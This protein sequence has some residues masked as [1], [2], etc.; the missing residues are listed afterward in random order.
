MEEISLKLE[1]FVGKINNISQD[2]LRM[3]GRISSNENNT[4]KLLNFLETN[5]RITNQIPDLQE[6]MNSNKKLNLPF[7][8]MA[9]SRYCSEHG[10]NF[11]LEKTKFEDTFGAS[12]FSQGSYT[13]GRSID[14]NPGFNSSI[15]KAT[16]EENYHS[17]QF[18]HNYN[19][20]PNQAVNYHQQN[21]QESV[22][23]S[24]LMKTTVNRNLDYSQSVNPYTNQNTV[25]SNNFDV[26]NPFRNGALMN[27]Q[28]PERNAALVN[29]IEPERNGA[30]LNSMEPE[31]K[32][33][34]SNSK[35]SQENYEIGREYMDDNYDRSLKHIYDTGKK[36][37]E[38]IVIEDEEIL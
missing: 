12:K 8:S 23:Q 9:N 18:E 7:D 38:T 36:V 10:N 22:Y 15:D 21:I 20:Q 24:N 17:P 19:Q 25:N 11:T 32:T 26:S 16:L 6:N 31:K 34:I 29:S 37:E 28:E 1:G 3:E 13:Q 14:R 4:K 30:L 27:S 35:H 5:N 2:I 33:L